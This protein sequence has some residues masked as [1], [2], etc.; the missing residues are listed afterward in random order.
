MLLLHLP[1]ALACQALDAKRR[2]ARHRKRLKAAQAELEAF[3]AE[4]VG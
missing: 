3:H 1:V 4:Q 2:V